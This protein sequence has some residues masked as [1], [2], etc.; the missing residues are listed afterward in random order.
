QA[1]GERELSSAVDIYAL[2]AILYELLTGR[3]PFKAPTVLDTVV[4]VIHEEV[5]PPSRLNA[6]VPRD[7]ETICLTCLRKDRRQRY[8]SAQFLGDELGCC[9]RGE[10]IQARAV[11][12]WERI[13]KRARRRPAEAA[14]F[15]VSFLAALALVAVVVSLLHAARLQSALDEAS[16][17]RQEAK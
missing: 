11:S 17:Q 2:G 7:L 15:G 6:K 8:A 10:P 9:L 13:I 4:Q 14:L 12:L 16:L 3:P 1:R 5:V